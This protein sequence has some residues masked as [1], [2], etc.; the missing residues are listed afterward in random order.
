MRGSDCRRGL[1][2]LAHQSTV[3][4]PPLLP[5]PGGHTA[6][7]RSDG[8]QKERSPELKWSDEEEAVLGAKRVLE[9][10]G[11]PRET[12]EERSGWGWRQEWMRPSGD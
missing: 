5:A 3:F 11:P 7:R 12:A 8:A 10:P 6:A 2:G 9:A 4:Q 1:G